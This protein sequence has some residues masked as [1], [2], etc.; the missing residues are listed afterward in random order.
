MSGSKICQKMWCGKCYTSNDDVVHFHMATDDMVLNP[1][2]DE[3]RL[4]SGWG[5]RPKDRNRFST[6]RNG[7]DLLVSF[8][9]DDCIFFKLYSRDPDINCDK[10]LFALACIRRIVLDAFWS[11]ARTTVESNT[12][13]IREGL[14]ISNRLGLQGPYLNPGPLPQGDHCGYEV[15][16]QM[17]VASLGSG[18][19][20][21]THKQ[22]DTIRKLRS[23]YSNQVR[24]AKDANSNVLTIADDKG[25]S[26]QRIAR[27]PCG[28]LWFQR[29]MLGCKKR[30][31]QDWRPNQAISIVL[32]H[33][34]LNGCET[35]A[36]LSPTPMHGASQMDFSRGIFLHLL[37]TL[38]SKSGRFNGR[39][40]R[41]PSIL[42][43]KQ[44]QH[45]CPSLGKGKR[46]ASCPSPPVI[47]EGNH[48]VR[49]TGQ[50]VGRT[51]HL[52]S[53]Y[54]WTNCGPCIC[55][56]RGPPVHHRRDE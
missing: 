48:R 55:Q 54:S 9:C 22:W 11:R 44:Q 14:R 3:D 2:G 43:S 13:K 56:S 5:S 12:A 36:R 20:S 49:Y 46:R 19:Y 51:S 27:D 34:L 38:S 1:A 18:R 41:T 30:M 45:N 23:S 7:D 28:S 37:C 50:V 15:A 8:E 16:L 24:A 6:A 40:G 29:F 26:Y 21:D 32:V 10:D 39:L 52:G 42:R 33:E 25:S 35:R 47:V 17:V 31:G 4:E 53:S